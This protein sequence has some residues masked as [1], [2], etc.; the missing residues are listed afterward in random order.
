MGR[1]K[2]T[3][4][5]S[6]RSCYFKLLLYA[7]NTQHMHALEI[8]KTD[9]PDYIGIAHIQTDESG[10]VIMQGEGKMHYHVYLAFANQRSVSVVCRSLD[11]MKDDGTPDDQFCRTITGRFDNALVYL[12]HAN[13]P[14]K[15]RYTC[16]ALFGSPALIERQKV[17]EMKYLRKEIDLSDSVLACLDWIQRQQDIITMS[18]FGRWICN[19]PYFRASS[20]PI[21]RG[22]IEEHNSRIYRA[23]ANARLEMYSNSYGRIMQQHVSNSDVDFAEWDGDFPI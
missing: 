17:A 4:S 22:A 10:E 5:G 6:A 2:N 19:T 18:Y 23:E 8:I 20:S 7:D 3:D 1:K 15:E 12:T 16:D 13:A 14:D 9:F 21:V 11:L